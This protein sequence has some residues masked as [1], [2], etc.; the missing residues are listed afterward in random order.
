[1]PGRH[2][3]CRQDD[4]H[5]RPDRR[6][7]QDSPLLRGRSKPEFGPPR[8]IVDLPGV[9]SSINPSPEEEL[10]CKVIEGKHTK[11]KPD[12]FVLVVDATQLERHLKFAGL[13]ARQGKPMVV[14]LTMVDLLS[15]RGQ[16]VDPV[17]L[18]NAIGVPVIPVDARSGKGVPELV[19]VLDD[20]PSHKSHSILADLP[21]DPIASY[22]H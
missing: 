21:N 14:A 15:R 3:Q 18:A 7:L 1:L 12:A 6:Q 17:K 20:D 8:N 10:A 19:R 2:A 13:V 16:A 4:P 11:V 5:E 9:H 22:T